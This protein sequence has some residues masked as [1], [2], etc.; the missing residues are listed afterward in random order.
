LLAALATACSTTIGV[1]RPFTGERLADIN[2]MLDDKNAVITYAPRGGKPQ[3]EDASAITLT[4]EKARW[5]EPEFARDRHA[6]PGQPVEAPID[7]V[8]KVTLCDSSCRGKGAL[9][10]AGLGLVAGLLAGAIGK[11]TCHGEYCG[12]WFL[13]GPVFAV[14]LGTLIGLGAGHRTIIELE[15]PAR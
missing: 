8:R 7:A 3:K 12:F 13:T 11:A 4:P 9:E 15:P 2:S 1:E 14:P 10:G 5:T 6:P